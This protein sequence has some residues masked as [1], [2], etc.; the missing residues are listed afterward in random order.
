MRPAKPLGRTSKRR[1]KNETPKDVNPTCSAPWRGCPFSTGRRWSPC[2]AGPGPRSTRP[3]RSWRPRGPAPPCSTPPPRFPRRGGSTLTA[4]GLRRLADEGR[5][6]PWTS[7]CA[8]VPSRRSGGRNLMER[9]DALAVIYPHGRPPLQRRLPHTVPLVPGVAPGR[10]RDAARRQDRRDRQAGH[11][12][13]PIGIRQAALAAARRADARRCPRPHGRRRAAPGTPGGCFR[14]P[15]CPPSSPWSARRSR[16][17]RTTGY[18]DRS[19]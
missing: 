2:R 5:T 11:H 10:R 1:P 3:S 4:A 14:P 8:P 12:R 15:T 18:G 13:G 7:W 19:R 16:R 6:S 17:V 9:L